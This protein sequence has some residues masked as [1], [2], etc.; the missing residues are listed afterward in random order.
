VAGGGGD[1]GGGGGADA[2]MKLIRSIVGNDGVLAAEELSS[3]ERTLR[4]VDLGVSGGTLGAEGGAVV[5][6]KVAERDSVYT[7][8]MLQLIEQ[9]LELVR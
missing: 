1:S 5:L 3:W 4:G 2:T 8:G 9:L 7:H 6:G